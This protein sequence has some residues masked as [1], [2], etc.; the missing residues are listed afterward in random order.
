MLESAVLAAG[1]PWYSR[2]ILCNLQARGNVEIGFA[3]AAGLDDFDEILKNLDTQ[4]AIEENMLFLNRSTSLE[5][6]NMLSQ[7][8]S[9]S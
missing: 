8:I 2:F 7:C 6:D 3:G 1:L 5:F 9:R 4:G